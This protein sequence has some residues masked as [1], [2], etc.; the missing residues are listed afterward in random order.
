MGH[1]LELS[2]LDWHMSFCPDKYP[3]KPVF[4]KANPN[5]QLCRVMYCVEVRKS[6]S[7]NTLFLFREK[8]KACIQAALQYA[9][10]KANA[11]RKLVQFCS[12]QSFCWALMWTHQ[13][14]CVHSKDLVHGAA[15]LWL[16]FL[17]RSVPS[18]TVDSVCMC[19]CT[20]P[21]TFSSG[22]NSS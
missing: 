17:V 11:A 19:A 21:N 3:D 13:V 16:V 22:K 1:V 14:V 6:K 18:D 10:I 15:V 9:C 5:E 8:I 20:C 12:R 2:S 7:V 4:P